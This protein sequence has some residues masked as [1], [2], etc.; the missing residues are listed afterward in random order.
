MTGKKRK[1]SIV[2]AVIVM[3]CGAVFASAFY[4]YKSSMD[5]E[6]ILAH[7]E[8]DTQ[9][10]KWEKISVDEGTT[11]DADYLWPEEKDPE[12]IGVYRNGIKLEENKMVTITSGSVY[13]FRGTS[14][15]KILYTQVYPNSTKS[16]ELTGDSATWFR[17]IP[18][19]IRNGFKQNGWTWETGP[20][21]DDRAYLDIENKK[22]IIAEDD[23][24]AVL[25]GMG[26]YLD[27]IYGYGTDMVFEQEKDEFTQKFG[28]SY[29]MF[30]MAMECYYTRGGEL[31]ST[32]PK[33]Y[34]VVDES[35]SRLDMEISQLHE[36]MEDVAN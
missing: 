27:N 13:H 32:C 26:L 14:E 25:Y 36:N 15:S 16:V 17:L 30:A 18:S 4:V 34:A 5:E 21:Y 9:D 8:T 22:I 6:H 33:I 28:E 10:F 7:A 29:N 12:F 2:T 23:A 3:V 11:V 35:L 31:R 19:A 24:A 1:D 20:S